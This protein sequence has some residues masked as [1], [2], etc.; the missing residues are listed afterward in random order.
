MPATKRSASGAN[1]FDN[2]LTATLV[3]EDAAL[4]RL[5]EKT[6][7]RAVSQARTGQRAGAE[8]RFYAAEGRSVDHEAPPPRRPNRGRD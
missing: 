1:M 8:T 5:A 2:E 3:A 6:S 7:V 4:G